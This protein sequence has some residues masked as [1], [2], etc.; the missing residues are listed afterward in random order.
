MQR[1]Y[2]KAVI[3]WWPT[4]TRTFPWRESASPYQV[5][6]GEVLLQRTRGENVIPVYRDFVRRW[7]TPEKLSQA[8]VG[9]IEKVIVI[10]NNQV[11]HEAK[12]GGSAPD[13]AWTDAAPPDA[14]RL[15]Y[16]V[17]VH[18]DDGHMAWSS[19]IWFDRKA[20]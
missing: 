7:P 11:V 14:P 12:P 6:I 5:L 17:R 13:L 20:E 9:T 2:R 3:G 4:N 10:R 8:R 18:R 1:I 15:W 19:P 16:Y